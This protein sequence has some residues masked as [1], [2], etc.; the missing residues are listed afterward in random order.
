MGLYPYWK[1][2][3]SLSFLQRALYTG[4]FFQSKGC[5]LS[6]LITIQYHIDSPIQILDHSLIS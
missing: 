2:S 3:S 5:Y 1:L 4:T 6:C